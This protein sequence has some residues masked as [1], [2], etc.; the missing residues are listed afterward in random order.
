MV[1]VAEFPHLAHRYAVRAVP[2]VVI[3]EKVSFEG[4]YPEEEFLRKVIEASAK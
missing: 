1:E 4:A 2:K 3:N